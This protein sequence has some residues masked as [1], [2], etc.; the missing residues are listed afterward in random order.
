MELV[1]YGHFSFIDKYLKLKFTHLDDSLEKLQKHCSG[2]TFPYTEDDFNVVLA[3]K[4]V[5]P[6]IKKLVGLDCRCR[7]KMQPYKFISK[8]EVNKGEEVEGCR[9]LLLDIARY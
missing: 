9:L 7:V 6:D 1:L 5:P 4:Y 3:T 2:T 8:L